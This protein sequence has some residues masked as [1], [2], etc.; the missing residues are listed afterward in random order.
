MDRQ[1]FLKLS[2]AEQQTVLFDML[3]F[4]DAK[5]NLCCEE[6]YLQANGLLNTSLVSVFEQMVAQYPDAVSIVYEGKTLTYARLNQLANQAAHFLLQKER[7]SNLVALYMEPSLEMIA[8]LIGILKAGYGYLP[9][10]TKNARERLE[11]ILEDAKPALIFSHSSCTPFHTAQEWI[12][13][14]THEPVFTRQTSNPGLMVQGN[15]LA[16][17]IYTSGSTGK[18]KG[19][20]ICH[21]NVINLFRSADLVF[22]FSKADIWT[23]FHSVSFD[24][25][26]WEI[27]G[28]LLK[29]GKLVMVPFRISRNFPLFYELLVQEHVTVLNQTPTAFRLLMQTDEYLSAQTQPLSLR[30]VIFGGEALNF[31]SLKPWVARH[32][33]HSPKLVNMFGI[34]ETTVHVTYREVSKNDLDSTES[35]IGYPLPGTAVFLL[36]PQGRPVDVGQTGEMYVSGF[37][38]AKGYLNRPTLT[39][40][41]F[42]VDPFKSAPGSFLYRTGDL[43]RYAPSGE[44]VYL[45]R[46]DDQVQIRGFRVE[47]AEIEIAIKKHPEIADCIVTAHRHQQDAVKLVAV[48]QVISGQTVSHSTLRNWLKGLL[49]DYMLPDL[50]V[51]VD[52]FPLNKNGKLDLSQFQ[53]EKVLK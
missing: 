4:S 8:G 38:L 52:T 25:S 45:G 49:P 50:S 14:D 15:A 42:V 13:L 9:L 10:D 11:A 5:K 39:T 43:A 26:V 17:V 35:F 32:G 48:I 16:Y 31:S 28:A 47:L 7:S 41:K 34:T 1:A 23:C 24:F 40:E 33:C 37:G 18:P 19:V 29:G 6:A 27:W 22:G 44:L 51:Q 3:G 2:G 46:A 12:F 20:P 30:Y 53:L 36:D 21:Y